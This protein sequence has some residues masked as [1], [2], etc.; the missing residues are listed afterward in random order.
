[1]VGFGRVKNGHPKD[2]MYCTLPL[3]VLRV[4][5]LSVLL[6]SPVYHQSVLELFSL[7]CYRIAEI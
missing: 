2:I 4:D 7:Q 6:F 3:R 1:M 5:T